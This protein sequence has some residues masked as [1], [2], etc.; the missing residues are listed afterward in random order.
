MTNG[1]TIIYSAKDG[2]TVISLIHSEPLKVYHK[3]KLKSWPK[4]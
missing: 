4:T 3:L 2:E 1:Q